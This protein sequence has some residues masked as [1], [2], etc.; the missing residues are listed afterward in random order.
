[1]RNPEGESDHGPLRPLFDRRLKLEFHGSRVTSDAGLLAYR[2]LDDALGLTALAGG[3]LADSRTGRNGWHGIVSL[4]RQSVY[5][6]LAGYEDVNDADRLGRDPAMRWIVG[7]KAVERGGAS[8]SQMGRFETELLAN[9]ENLAALA[10]LS[11]MWIDRVHDHDPPRRVVLDMD[12]SVS[13]TFGEQEG[14][15]YN[16]HFG[17]TC[18]HPLFVFN[19][20]G[21][22]ER[23]ALRPGNVHSAH[24]WRDVLVPVVE[25]YKE[26]AIR[27][28][29]RGDAAFA[30]PE[31]YDYLEAEGMLYA[32][33]LPANKVLQESIAHLLKRP[34]GRPPR[35]VR[36][37]HA[38]FS[39]QAGTWDKP[40]RVVAKVEWHPGE[41]YPR[42]GFI[43]TNLG[44]PAERVV[45]FYNQ[46]G[47]AEQWIKEGKNAIRWTRLSC[48]RFRPQRRAAPASCAGLQ[49]RELH[50]HPGAA[51]GGRA[52]VVDER[53][54][55]SWSR[56]VQRSS[57]SGRYVTS[58]RWRRLSFLV[59][60]SPTSCAVST[61]SD[62]RQ[63]RHERRHPVPSRRRR[64]DRCARIAGKNAIPR[65]QRRQ[66]V[67]NHPDRRED[68]CHSKANCTS[69]GF[70]SH[71]TGWEG[72]IWGIPD[73]NRS[74]QNVL[75]TLRDHDCR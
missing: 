7:G 55:R 71:S 62:R 43:V 72:S 45:A 18:Y 41:L 42:V 50:A 67:L 3:V 32:I 61:G 6:R 60:C 53:C 8:T 27:L 49:P 38:S 75:D 46:R 59:T 20:F 21:D 9:D 37:Y 4:L 56:S 66:L 40:R 70:A 25:R 48:R 54:A 22:L 47:T 58:S 17:C 15:A 26:R 12:S 13:P 14:T 30:S 36:R 57:A 10:D 52:V 74:T 2:E 65:H 1:M 44:R 39:Y 31:I 24:G 19:Q 51:R 33:R 73:I 29:F 28:Y 35:D 16:G 64:Q 63:P 23:C 34:V 68:G 11:G 69:S 5:G